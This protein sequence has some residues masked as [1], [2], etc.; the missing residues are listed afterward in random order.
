MVYLEFPK[1]RSNLE[2]PSPTS[3][4]PL[5]MAHIGTMDMWEDNL[6]MGF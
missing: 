6:K 4:K 3:G 2:L 5:N 1:S